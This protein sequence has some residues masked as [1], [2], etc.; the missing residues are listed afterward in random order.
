VDGRY[1]PFDTA[2][3]EV[4]ELVER[5]P[6]LTGVTGTVDRAMVLIEDFEEATSIA[7]REDPAP[8]W[9]EL[10]ESEKSRVLE[11]R[12]RD[13]NLRQ[14]DAELARLLE[15][16]GDVLTRRVPRPYRTVLDDVQA[17]LFNCA[18][19]RGFLG[20]QGRLFEFILTAY[21]LGGWPCG[22]QGRF[23]DGELL[24]FTARASR[25]R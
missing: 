4:I 13:P 10:R 19:S 21:Q 14:R 23:P 20:K 7:W 22:W 1:G 25:D 2:V 3:D 15:R 16:F 9:N 11:I 8:T 24:V 17:D 6:M 5:G 18:F 12:Y